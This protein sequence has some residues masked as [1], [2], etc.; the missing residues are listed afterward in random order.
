MWEVFSKKI[1]F[2]KRTLK[3]DKNDNSRKNV[4]LHS[5]NSIVCN[6]ILK[7]DE[8]KQYFILINSILF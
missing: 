1:I 7:N 3:G 8:K 6:F 2:L 5:G 4:F